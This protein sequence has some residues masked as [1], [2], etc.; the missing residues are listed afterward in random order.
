MR[1]LATLGYGTEW[2]IAALVAGVIAGA[3]PL[4]AQQTHRRRAPQPSHNMES[5][6]NTDLPQRDVVRVDTPQVQRGMSDVHRVRPLVVPGRWA[7][8]DPFLALMED[9][10]PQGVFD[11]HPHRGFETV[12]YVIEGELEHYDNHGNRGT[13]AAGDAQWM[14]AGRGI[15]HNEQPLAG[16]TV[17]SLQLWL[18]LPRDR[19]LV[20]ARHQHLTGDGVPVRR[21]PGAELRVFSGE[22]GPIRSSTQNYTPVTMIEVRLASKAEIEQALPASYNAFVVLIEGSGR[23]GKSSATVA[24]GQVAWLAQHHEPSALRMA[25]GESGLRALW[26]AGK[27]LREPV[28][29]RGPFVM[30]TEAEL[31]DSF[32][33]FRIQGER[34]GL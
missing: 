17:H 8:T 26:F 18:N 15:I 7:E 4:A 19:K 23:I 21:E 20:P 33:E 25:A 34:F 27:P 24:A 9:W 13:L 14:T 30:N 29:A 28:A 12:T 32:K 10:F 3:I 31:A 6:M 22:S 16:G 2:G 1:C 5:S 11:R